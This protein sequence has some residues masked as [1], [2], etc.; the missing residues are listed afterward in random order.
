MI[1]VCLLV[2]LTATGIA[3]A[4]PAAADSCTAH[5]ANHGVTKAVDIAQHRAGIH[6]GVS[7]CDTDDEASTVSEKKSEDRDKKSRYCRKRWFC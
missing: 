4:P 6:P 1:K 7:P 5:L 3:V 2:G